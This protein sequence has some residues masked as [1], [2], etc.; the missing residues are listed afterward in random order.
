MRRRTLFGLTLATTL[1]ASGCA[2]GNDAVNQSAGGERGYVPTGTGKQQWA[3]GQ[4]VAAP[5]ITGTTLTGASFALSALR[6][7]VVV[8]NFWGQWCAPCRA[9]SA[10]LQQ[11]YLATKAKGVEFVGVNIRD[12]QDRALAFERT[13]GITYPSLF[14]PEGRIGVKFPENA[15]HHDPVHHRV[16]PLWP[17]RGPVPGCRSGHR[18]GARRAVP[19]R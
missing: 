14:D 6:G 3:I 19:G 9:E 16:G 8:I 15:A 10:D 2:V 13:N 17:G 12:T 4:R 1:L 5:E 7:K 18:P 11:A